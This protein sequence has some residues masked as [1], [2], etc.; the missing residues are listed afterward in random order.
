MSTRIDVISYCYNGYNLHSYPA[1]SKK[2][3]EKFM[4]A[5]FYRDNSMEVI[6]AYWSIPD[7]NSLPEKDDES[8]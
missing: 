1:S 8:L 3:V 5:L 7:Y 4:E 2:G 6:V